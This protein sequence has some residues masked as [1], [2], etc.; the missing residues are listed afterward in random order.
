MAT[1][2]VPAGSHVLL[3]TFVNS[4]LFKSPLCHQ[5][6]K[7]LSAL[8]KCGELEVV[9]LHPRKRMLWREHLHSRLQSPLASQHPHEASGSPQRSK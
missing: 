7:A 8:F 6:F 9:V 5:L 4:L 3:P 1:S 2:N